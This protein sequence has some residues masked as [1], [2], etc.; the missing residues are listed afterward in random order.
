MVTQYF[1]DEG[2][3]F[4]FWKGRVALYAILKALN[5]GLGDEVIIP[6]F[7]CVVVPNAILYL[8][9]KPVYADIET[10]TYNLSAATIEPLINNCTRVIIAQNTYGLSADLDPIMALAKKYNL[11]VIEDCAHGLGGTYRGKRNGTVAHAAFF[12]TQW[13]KP[14]STG[15]GGVAYIKDNIIIREMERVVEELEIPRPSL[16]QQTMLYAQLLARPLADSP[17]LHYPLVGAYRFLTQKMGLSVGSSTKDELATVEMPPGYVKQ[18][19]SLQLRGWRRGLAMLDKKV[20]QRQKVAAHYDHFFATTGIKPPHQPAYA[21]HAMLRYSIRVS[22]KEGLLN[23]AQK[24]HIPIGDWFVSP[25]H[26]VSDDL[27]RWGYQAGQC[28]VAEQACREI[29]NLYSDRPLSQEQLT[30]LFNG[31]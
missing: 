7:T 13:S 11:V 31:E 15:L 9:A 5:I 26:P 18:M 27:S 4:Y 29:I 30:L 14:I 6:G 21:K 24:M 12:S 2:Q 17:F 3:H 23:K 20:K 25:L 22:D 8:E 28:P 19:G 16:G 1:P 10:N